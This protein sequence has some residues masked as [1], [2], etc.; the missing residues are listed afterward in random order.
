[1]STQ[2][3]APVLTRR[4]PRPLAQTRDQYIQRCADDFY[5]WQATHRPADNEFLLHDGPPYANGDLHAGHALNK[6]LKD[7]ILRVKVQ[8]G[9]HFPPPSLLYPRPQPS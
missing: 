4:R 1:M 5:K 9:A 7:I 2:Q 8:Q 6:I 3:L